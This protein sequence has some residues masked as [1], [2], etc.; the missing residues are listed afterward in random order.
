MTR[1][2]LSANQIKR[3][4]TTS[5]RFVRSHPPFSPSKTTCR[6][7]T[8]ISKTF[9]MPCIKTVFFV[10]LQADNRSWK[11]FREI[12]IFRV[13][14]PR[15][16]RKT[17]RRAFRPPHRTSQRKYHFAKQFEVGTRLEQVQFRRQPPPGI[18]IGATGILIGATHPCLWAC[19]LE[20]STF[21]GLRK[22][23]GELRS[24]S[25][26]GDGAI[27]GKTT[28]DELRLRAIAIPHKD[29]WPHPPTISP[30][31]L[32]VCQHCGSSCDAG[33]Q[34]DDLHLGQ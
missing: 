26:E 33:P 21:Q 10:A 29:G 34:R 2:T 9:A 30:A 12:R 14:R 3:H 17:P 6:S 16:H 1:K 25:L 31:D 8:W 7:P 13:T 15:F 4:R 11:T 19:F 24:K 23:D 20:L 28:K 18:L 5:S 22:L 32:I 27:R